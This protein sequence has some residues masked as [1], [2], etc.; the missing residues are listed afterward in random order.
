MR[1]FRHHIQFL[2]CNLCTIKNPKMKT[3]FDWAVEKIVQLSDLPNSS[4]LM[5]TFSIKV[6]GV[7][8]CLAEAPWAVEYGSSLCNLSL[9]GVGLRSSYHHTR[10]AKE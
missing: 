6:D 1:E 2:A 7:T 10:T 8:V 5:F 9:L 3:A 4:I